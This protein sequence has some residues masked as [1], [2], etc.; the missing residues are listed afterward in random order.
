MFHSIVWSFHVH[1]LAQKKTTQLLIA[2]WPQVSAPPLSENLNFFFSSLKKE[3]KNLVFRLNF[4]FFLEYLNYEDGKFSKSRGIGV[5]GDNAKETGIPAD[6][7]R[8][9]LLYVRPESQVRN[10]LFSLS[11]LDIQSETVKS[12]MTDDF[13]SGVNEAILWFSFFNSDTGY[14]SHYFVC[15][16]WAYMIDLLWNKIFT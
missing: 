5:F 1:Y 15:T 12:N 13:T 7:F 16:T 8:F 9:Y 14:S 11:R 4:L 3:K 2:L 6:I 10:Y